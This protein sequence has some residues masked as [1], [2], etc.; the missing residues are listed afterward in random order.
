MFHTFTVILH[1]FHTFLETCVC[2]C[3]L[4]F[5][6]VLGEQLKEKKKKKVKLEKSLGEVQKSED[7]HVEASAKQVKLDTSKWPLLLKVFFWH[8][9]VF[10]SNL[11]GHLCFI[12]F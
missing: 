5:A 8:T 12:A 4:I 11:Y 3:Y 6:E 10:V 2:Y 1:L 7:F 9:K